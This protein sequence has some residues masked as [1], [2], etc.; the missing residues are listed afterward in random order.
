[1]TRRPGCSD[2][3]S[4]QARTKDVG[5][6]HCRI[7]EHHWGYASGHEGDSALAGF[8]GGELVVYTEAG[9]EGRDVLLASG[10]WNWEGMCS[11]RAPG[12]R[13]SEGP[14]DVGSGH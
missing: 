2:A 10:A 11:H 12:Q 4:Y 14:G 1:M 13:R 6:N 3:A 9:F 7:R 8:A 5:A